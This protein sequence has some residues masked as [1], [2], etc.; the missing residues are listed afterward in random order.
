MKKIKIFWLFVSVV[1]TQRLFIHIIYFQLITTKMVSKKN[2]FPLLFLL[3]AITSIQAQSGF[4]K[5]DNEFRNNAKNESENQCGGNQAAPIQFEGLKS[6]AMEF[7]ISSHGN[8]SNPGTRERPFKTLVKA[9]NIV[10]KY[11]QKRIKEDIFVWL[12]GGEYRFSETLVFGLND[13]AKPGQTITYCAMPDEKPIIS[14]DVPISNWKKLQKMPKDLPQNAYGKIWVAEIPKSLKPFKVLFNSQGMLP[15]ARTKAIAHLR[16]S[17]DWSGTD[18]DHTTIPFL[19]GTTDDLFNPRNAEILVIPAAPWTMNILPVKSVDAVTGMVYLGASSTYALA[20]PRYYM[21]PEAIWVENTFAGLDAPGKWVFDADARLLYYWPL[22]NIMPGNDIVVPRLIEMVRVEGQVDYNGPIDIPVKGLTFKGL[23]FTHGNRFESS[24]QTGR[25]LQHDWERFDESTALFRFR[26]AE[27][28]SVENCT[29]INSGG[30]GI[31]LD[32]YAKNIKVANNELSELGGIGI[33]LAGYGPGTKDVNKKNEISNN[34]IRHIGRLWWHSLGIWAWQSGHNLIS[35]NTIHNVPYTA[36][37]VTGRIGWDKSGKRECSRTVRWAETGAFTGRESWEERER[38]LHGR[39]NRIEDNDIHH[40]MDVMQDGSGVYISGAGHGNVVGGNYVHDTPGMAAGE[41]IRCDDDQN[42]TIIENNVV[43]HYGTHG[44]GICSKRRN[45]IF[46]NIIACP[47]DRVNRGMLSIEADSK[48]IAGS[49]IFRNIFYATQPN[50]PFVGGI[51]QN[52]FNT[53]EI[54][55]NIYFNASDPKVADAYLDMARK[56]NC[57]GGSIQADPMF[58][59][60]EKGDFH[61]K[62]NS[63]V[64]QMG[65]RPFELNVG[66]KVGFISKNINN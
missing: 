14:S 10:Q 65:F 25:G 4:S 55:G 53:I 51:D 26:G 22:D 33:L 46:N 28:C 32:L 21:G 31:R 17:S 38:F 60:P 2:I 16:K 48:A 39:Q 47:P 24:G 19:K 43:F 9:R 66:R 41:A 3:F 35:H 59:D 37:A 12:S 57:E 61:F 29:F 27:N 30:A 62:P 54:D 8:D 36:I 23:T 1:A 15:R 11:N 6:N 34:Y 5:I 20:A 13:S 49:R 58:L 42:E 7:Y 52:K 45:H 18:E 56:N 40:V 50:Q 64:V 63:P 44:V